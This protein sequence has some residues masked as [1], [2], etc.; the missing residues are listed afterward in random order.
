MCIRDRDHVTSDTSKPDI[1]KLTPEKS[2][3]N[4]GE[5]FDIAYTGDGT[6][7]DIAKV[8]LMFGKKNSGVTIHFIDY[9]G[10]GT[11]S[12]LIKDNYASSP[13]S[14]LSNNLVNGEYE[15]SYGEITDA[16]GNITRLRQEAFDTKFILKG[17][18]EL[19]SDTVKPTMKNV[20][21]D[22][23]EFDFGTIASIKYTGDGTGSDILDVFFNFKDRNN[24]SIFFN[25]HD[26]D[27]VATAL[28]NSATSHVMG[29]EV[30][31]EIS[32]GDIFTL[33]AALIYDKG[34]NYEGYDSRDFDLKFSV[35]V[36]RAT[37]Q[38]D[39]EAPE[40]DLTS[41]ISLDEIV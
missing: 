24:K 40:L 31:S 7:S 19:A 30:E 3:A 1:T 39:F 14:F 29:E 13:S 33:N 16:G 32:N 9:E 28:L 27:G 20:T 38:T 18:N 34:G 8:E 2:E 41:F 22:K 15:F 35:T 12:A 23:T 4:W 6:G 17:A 37:D 10:D 5:I 21:L 11:A 36:P 25:D 26:G